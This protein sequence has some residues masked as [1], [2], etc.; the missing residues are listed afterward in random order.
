MLN[1]GSFCYWLIKLNFISQPISIICLFF[2]WLI[3]YIPKLNSKMYIIFVVHWWNTRFHCWTINSTNFF[4][5]DFESVHLFSFWLLVQVCNY[6]ATN[7]QN[8]R[9]FFFTTDCQIRGFE[10]DWFPKCDAFSRSIALTHNYFAA[11][12]TLFSPFVSKMHNIFT[13][14]D[15]IKLTII[16]QENGKI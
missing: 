3:P 6:F 15:W 5:N 8:F 4:L 10:Q 11:K 7:K 13:T 1:I 2:S 9:F 16:L 14:F 12:I